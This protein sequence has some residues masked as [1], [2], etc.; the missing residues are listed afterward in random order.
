MWWRTFS[1]LSVDWKT[2]LGVALPLSSDSAPGSRHLLIIEMRA[3]WFILKILS[4]PI[5]FNCLNNHSLLFNYK[6][7]QNL[8]ISHL[9]WSNFIIINY[10]Y[11][12]RVRSLGMLVSDWLTNSLTNSCLV[13]LIDV[14]LACEDANSKLVEVVTAADCMIY[15]SVY[16]T[17]N[18]QQIWRYIG[19][20][21]TRH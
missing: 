21:V 8:T 20:R 1:I 19:S 3:T 18:K 16:F 7:N 17:L 12:T 2:F 6:R 13:N 9:P 5:L 4:V 15:I 14:S 11:R 10:F